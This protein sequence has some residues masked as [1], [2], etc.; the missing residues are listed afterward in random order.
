MDEFELEE[1]EPTTLLTTQEIMDAITYVNEG[2]KEDDL[3]KIVTYSKRMY[4]I[5]VNTHIT[6][7]E[8]AEQYEGFGSFISMGD[9]DGLLRFI[10]TNMPLMEEN[11][12]RESKKVEELV[13]VIDTSAS[14]QTNLVQHFLNET[15]SILRSRETFFHRIELRILE[16]D[17]QVQKDILIRSPEE[18]QKYLETFEVSGGFGT[19]FRP[20]FE[21]VEKLRTEGQIF[22]F[23]PL[24]EDSNVLMF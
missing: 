12:Y 4:F 22:L 11:E 20:A 15:A 23:S 21:Y 18:M 2:G 17:N 10:R 6:S 7:R 14:T 1:S 13:I 3:A 16:C 5:A 9:V 8:I 24:E 19:D